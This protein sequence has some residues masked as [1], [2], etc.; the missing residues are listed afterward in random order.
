[1]RTGLCIFYMDSRSQLATLLIHSLLQAQYLNQCGSGIWKPQDPKVTH[2][3]ETVAST[4][5]KYP[6]IS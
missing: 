1:M 6:R 3:Q 2:E 5:F 4:Q